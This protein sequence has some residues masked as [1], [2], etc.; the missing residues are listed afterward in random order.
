MD[1]TELVTTR[2]NPMIDPQ[3]QVWEWE[4]PIYLFLGGFVAGMMIISGFFLWRGRHQRTECV[5]FLLPG[6]GVM[7]LSI[8]MLALFMDLEHKPYAWRLYT[9][10]QITSPMSWGAWILLL[11]YPALIANLLLRIPDRL[12]GRFPGLK[13]LSDRLMSNVATVNTVG[14]SN[15]VLGAGLG[16]Y[17]G[18][19]LSS[20][21]AR[22]L[23]SS[24]ILAVLFIVSGLSGAAAFVHLIARDSEERLLLAKADNGF[25]AIELVVLALFILFLLTAT[26]VHM[27]AASLLLTGQY[28]AVFWVFVVM[29]GIVIPLFYQSLSVNHKVPHNPLMPIFV[30]LGGLVLRFV[31][32]EAGQASHWL[33]TG[34]HYVAMP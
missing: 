18:I 30:M 1:L 20:L 29:I 28:A 23:W 7:L 15:M 34:L 12:G 33:S 14:I 11:V 22:P 19:L 16:L 32:V 4:I 2:F 24:P 8:G 25:L 6:L 31:I 9:T 26:E 10:F 21:G 13:Y 17:T 27:Q 3:V 5:C